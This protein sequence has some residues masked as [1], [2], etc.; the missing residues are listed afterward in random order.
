VAKEWTMGQFG[1]LRRGEVISLDGEL[2]VVVA[3]EFRNPGNWRAILQVK[4][5]NLRSGSTVERRFRPQDKVEVVFVDTHEAEYLYSD[6]KRH[7][8]METGSYEEVALP[9]D[10]LGDDVLYLLPN[11]KV[12]M[13]LYNNKPISVE[14]PNSVR[15][16]VKETEP[17]I[18]GATAQ[19]Q[20]KPAVTETGLKISVPPFVNP[21]DLIEIDTRTG[22]YVS[23]IGK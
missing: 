14:L 18:R 22:E 19:T 16:T 9:A 7:H 4:L 5:K 23:R 20:Y 11:T 6:G 12:Q 2:F 15:H 21:G 1:D 13:K 3:T 10:L 8:F 17:A